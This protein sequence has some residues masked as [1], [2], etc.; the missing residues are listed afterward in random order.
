MATSHNSPPPDSGTLRIAPIAALPATLHELGVDPAP[1]LRRFGIADAG[2]FQDSEAVIGLARAGKLLEACARETRCPH[3]GLLVGQH[4]HGDSLGALGLL[5]SSAPDV[6]SALREMVSNFDVHDRGATAF[7]TIDGDSV[8]LGYEIYARGVMGADLISDCALAIGWNIMRSL[9][10]PG[11]LPSEVCLRHQQPLA[12]EPYLRY[13]K[14]PLKFNAR[15]SGLVFPARWLDQPIQ[16]AD[17]QFRRYLHQR[18]QAMRNQANLGFREQ[19]QRALAMLLG[20][21][22]CTLAQLAAHFALHPR[23]LNRRLQDAGTSFRELLGETGQE[24]ARQLL[25]DTRRSLPSIAT[26]LGYADETSFNRAFSRREGM[27]PAKWRRQFRQPN[28]LRPV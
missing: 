22:R 4:G 1:L 24:M 18:L 26:L 15:H 10:G 21:Q 14:A 3:F 13:F 7:L 20:R 27:S 5:L 23:T 12:V 9:C 11:W 6:R 28:P 19:A 2:I 16:P 25:R 8:I 17:P